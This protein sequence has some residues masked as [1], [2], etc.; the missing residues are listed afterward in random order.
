MYIQFIFIL[1]EINQNFDSDVVIILFIGLSCNDEFLIFY[2]STQILIFI[3]GQIKLITFVNG[4]CDAIV[5][6]STV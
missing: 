1:N 6:V 2:N 3:T 4:F 5:L